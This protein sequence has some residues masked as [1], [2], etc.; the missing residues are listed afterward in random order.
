MNH[1]ANTSSMEWRFQCVT[2]QWISRI[3]ILLSDCLPF[4]WLKK[5]FLCLINKWNGL[6]LVFT[7]NSIFGCTFFC[8][9]C[10]RHCADVFLYCTESHLCTLYVC[11]L[12]CATNGYLC[13]I[14][15]ACRMIWANR[16]VYFSQI[17]LKRIENKHRNIWAHKFAPFL[18]TNWKLTNSHTRYTHAWHLYELYTFRIEFIDLLETD[19]YDQCVQCT[20]NWATDLEQQKWNRMLA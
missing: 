16:L 17:K 8:P 6:D 11:E 14:V 1:P 4:K 18:V 5:H 13:G 15:C 3:F 7:R 12:I 10:N 2:S 20:H 9:Q 19:F